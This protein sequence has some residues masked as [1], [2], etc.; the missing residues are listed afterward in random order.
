MFVASEAEIAGYSQPVLWCLNSMLHKPQ[1]AQPVGNPD[2]LLFSSNPI[3]TNSF[4][5]VPLVA[6]GTEFNVRKAVH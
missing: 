3:I 5:N 1:W 2:D 6:L 4:T